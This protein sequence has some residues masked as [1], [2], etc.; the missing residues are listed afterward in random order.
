MPPALIFI[1]GYLKQLLMFLSCYLQFPGSTELTTHN[2]ICCSFIYCEI[3]GQKLGIYSV[4]YSICMSIRLNDLR[5]YGQ[6]LKMLLANVCRKSA[7][8]QNHQNY[9]SSDIQFK[10]LALFNIWGCTKDYTVQKHMLLQAFFICKFTILCLLHVVNNH[11]LRSCWGQD[12]KLT[13]TKVTID[14]Q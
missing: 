6:I 11:L 8:H 12:L 14:L 3:L 10:K 9:I 13:M 1:R 2:R 7:I 4:K 5:P